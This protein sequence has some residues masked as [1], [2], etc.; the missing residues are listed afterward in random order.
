MARLLNQTQW[1]LLLSH[2]PR[3]KRRRVLKLAN[4]ALALAGGA[5]MTG[6]AIVA[7]GQRI[8]ASDMPHPS[9]DLH[10]DKPQSRL[11]LST[12]MKRGEMAGWVG[13][14]GHR[15]MLKMGYRLKGQRHTKA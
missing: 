1:S 5:M 4:E 2:A 13:G 8:G 14:L 3:A 11:P 15:T 6:T 10:Y 9:Q 12:P 7:P